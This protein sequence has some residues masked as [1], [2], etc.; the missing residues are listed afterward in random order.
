[1]FC[2]EIGDHTAA[3]V[4]EYVAALALCASGDA[5]TA[6]IDFLVGT[7]SVSGI[8]HLRWSSP[9]APP[10]LEVAG[11]VAAVIGLSV[12]SPLYRQANPEGVERAEDGVE[13]LLA[14]EEAGPC[15]LLGP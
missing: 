7:A 4:G 14:E 2:G 15:A 6:G 10:S 1:L 8:A 5:A 9:H 12:P 13:A 11:V 3:A